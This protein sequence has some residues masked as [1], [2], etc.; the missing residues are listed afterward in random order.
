MKQ[1]DKDKKVSLNDSWKEKPFWTVGDMVKYAREQYADPTIDDNWSVHYQAWHK[2]ITRRLQRLVSKSKGDKLKLAP[3]LAKLIIDELM[4]SYFLRTCK[5]QEKKEQIKQKHADKNRQQEMLKKL[6]KEYAQYDKEKNEQ[7]WDRATDH[8]L[9]ESA[10]GLDDDGYQ[11]GYLRVSSPEEAEE[12]E[13]QGFDILSNGAAIPGEFLRHSLPETSL[14][15]MGLKEIDDIV[16]KTMIR[17]V[18]EKF[19]DFKENAF[20]TDLM[21][22]AAR[23]TQGSMYERIYEDGYS[24]LTMQLENPIEHYITSKER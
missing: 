13:K 16:Y 1:K 5:D 23:I 6:A 17:A 10:D 18:F 7:S 4:Y 12:K 2:E 11:A 21:E 14:N 8:I 15:D 20:R 3:S 19:F 9:Q 22:R 24:A